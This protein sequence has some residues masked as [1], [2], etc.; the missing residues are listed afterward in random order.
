MPVMPTLT[1]AAMP[2]AIRALGYRSFIT[3]DSASFSHRPILTARI[4]TPSSRNITCT[5]GFSLLAC[6]LARMSDEVPGTTTTLTPWMRSKAGN[7]YLVYERSMS[8]PFMP[9]YSVLSWAS[10]LPA[11][12]RADRVHKLANIGADAVDE[13]FFRAGICGPFKLGW[14]GQ[15]AAGGG[16]PLRQVKPGIG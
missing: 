10:A 13:V 1:P 3:G 5:G 14:T 2:P 11:S 9:M 4:I 12:I 15:G 7:T 8:P 6:T 16:L